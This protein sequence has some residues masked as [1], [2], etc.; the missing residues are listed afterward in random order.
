MDEGSSE[1]RSDSRNYFTPRNI[2]IYLIVAALLYGAIYFLFLNKN[3]TGQPNNAMV[4]Q[5]SPT[6]A[7]QTSPTEA[8][9]KP[10]TVTLDTQNDSGESGTAVLSEETEGKTKVVLTISGAPKD[11]AQPAHIHTGA[12]PK[13]G[14]VVYPL[15]NVEN[16]TSETT[17]DVDLETLME[18][19]PLAINVHKSATQSAIYVACGDLK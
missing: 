5:A 10:M 17:I 4:P 7:A 9:A 2:I 13:P 3:G 12:C 6:A 1:H 15:T 19:Q 16:G 11:V 18:Q 8:M 14:A